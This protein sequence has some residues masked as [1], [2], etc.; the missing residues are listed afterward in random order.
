[1]KELTF[2]PRIM[3]CGDESEFFSHVGQ[4]SFKIVGHVNF[5]GTVNGQPFN[6]FRDG[7]IFLNNEIQHF[8]ELLK[9]I[10]VG[11][12]D[13]LIFNSLGEFDTVR[14]V[15]NSIGFNSARIITLEQFKALPH[16]FFCDVNADIK[17]LKHLKNIS[18]KTLLD[19]DGCFAK[20]KLFTKT[21]NY[22]TEIDCISDSPLLPIKENFYRRVFK[23]LAE[24]GFKR[25]D[26]ALIAERNPVEFN[27]MFVMLE[28]FTDTVITHARTGSELEKYFFD[29]ANNFSK[30]EGLRTASGN[31][32]F[33]TRHKPHENF[34]IYVVTH[35]PAPHDDK[36]PEGYKIIHAGRALNPDLGYLGDNTGDN[37]SEL[38]LYLNE[39]TALYWFWRN[40]NDSVVGLCHYRRFFTESDDTTFAYEKILTKDA[41]LKILEDY[42]MLVVFHSDCKTQHEIIEQDCDVELT[43]LGEATIRKYLLRS[44]PDYLDAFDYVLSSTTF[45]KCNMFVTRRNIL[46]AYC[47]WLFSFIIDAT[48]EILRAVNT[49][50]RLLGFFAER[51]LSVWLIKNHLRI[52]ELDIMEVKNI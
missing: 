4:R 33:L 28:N 23:N 3:L 45:Y 49:S 36:L 5:V 11:G 37:I 15:L 18:L 44:Q 32:F 46:D 6:F 40:A 22:F 43:A 51:M 14:N 16:E 13:Y 31:W 41:A 20:G 25:Y 42:D 35:K 52:K 48:K 2:M 24:V 50:H 29:N 12:I 21:G 10:R 34:C 7:K 9:M 38:N 27:S 1:M 47:K 17:L 30:A 8:G 19:A 39:I 26:A